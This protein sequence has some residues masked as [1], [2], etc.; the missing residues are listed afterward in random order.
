V[1]AGVSADANNASATGLA[2]YGMGIIADATLADLVYFAGGPELLLGGVGTAAASSNGT[3][4]GSA[5][6]GP[7]FS[8]AARTGFAF[9]S[10]RP[11]RRKAFTVGLDAHVVFA[12][13]TAVL[14]MLALGYESF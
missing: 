12:G 6:T 7:F 11:D 3:A 10:K 13:G 14:P 2:L 9:G 5:S 8:L 1:G 4:S